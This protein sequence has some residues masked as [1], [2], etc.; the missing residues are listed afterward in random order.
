[1]IDLT[2][3]RYGMLVAEFF[4][5]AEKRCGK[6]RYYWSFKCDCGNS[7]I[8]NRDDA[9]WHKTISCGCYS[10]KNKMALKNHNTYEFEENQIIGYTKLGEKF[11]IDKEDFDLIKDFYWYVDAGYL[12][13]R[14][15]INGKRKLFA[16]H[17]IIMN[18]KE[19]EMIDHINQDR[20]D[21]RKINL[22]LA[23]KSKN[24]MN[25]KTRSDN[26]SGFNGVVIWGNRWR[27]QITLN[28]KMETI[29]YFDTF[30]EAVKARVA[31]EIELFGQFSP[32]YNKEET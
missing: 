24:A 15:A 31:K 27:A 12:K 1:M 30:E 11:I 3:N 23:N 17:R 14:R 2:G 13:N 32:F 6:H 19:G 25:S 26:T 20:S 9:I 16:M 21:N 7:K 10:M 4:H 22:R 8:I 5:H 18:A 29:G 28:Q